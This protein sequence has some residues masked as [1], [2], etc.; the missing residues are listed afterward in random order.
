MRDSI[1]RL[2]IQNKFNELFG[3][4]KINEDKGDIKDMSRKVMFKTITTGKYFLE[5]ML[6]DIPEI[7][8]VGFVRY[9]DG[10]HETTFE[11][12]AYREIEIDG[13]VENVRCNSYGDI[14]N[15]GELKAKRKVLLDNYYDLR[16][17]DR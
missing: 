8:I 10:E 2:R 16:K 1:K 17:G 15:F 12:P 6:S 5:V 14:S 4:V 3:R 7:R 13:V 9:K 11:F